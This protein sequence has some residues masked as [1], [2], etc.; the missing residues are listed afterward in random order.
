MPDHA[1]DFTI[2]VAS[3]LQAESPEVW[4]AITTPTGVNAEL[5]PIQMSFPADLPSIDAASCGKNL[6]QSTI[7]LF[8][9][10][11]IDR[12]HFGLADIT[13]GSQFHEIS[14]S[15]IMRRW[16]HRR[17]VT[18]DG[19]GCIVRDHVEA[20]MR[21]PFLGALLGKVYR[22]VFERRH[23]CLRRRFGGERITEDDSMRE[24]RSRRARPLQDP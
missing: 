3:R 4:A 7:T 11:P 22:H 19:T 2:D 8:G 15:W 20:S 17:T 24:L 13:P 9:V 1:I 16:V 14:T 10:L 18:P 12:H 6:F 5:W 21:L 23:R